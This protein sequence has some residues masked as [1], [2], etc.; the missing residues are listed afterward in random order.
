MP[1]SKSSGL[2]EPLVERADGAVGR[3]GLFRGGVGALAAIG[4]ASVLTACTESSGDGSAA[5][6]SNNAGQAAGGTSLLQTIKKTK[7][8]SVGVNLATPALQFKDEK[9]QEP[10]GY[11]IEL[12]KIMATDLDVELEYVEQPF[13]DLFTGLAAGRFQMSGIAATILPSRASQVLFAAQPAFIESQVVLLKPGKKISDLT[14]LNSGD[15]TIAVR[16]GSSQSQTG[17]KMFPKAK[18]KELNEITAVTQDVSSG[19]ADAAILS[20]FAAVKPLEANPEMTVFNGPPVF[21]DYNSYFLPYN[22][23]ELKAWIDN[24]MSYQISHNVLATLWEEWV[25][26]GARKHNL[27]TVAVTS[28]Y[29]K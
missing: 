21:V 26:P 2:A 13:A 23:F 22:D 9:T 12:L 6:A 8:L 3:R 25:V 4:A 16:L 18:F 29:L 1:E 5:A 17:R 24:W 27:N 10:T 14:D 28:A 19:R 15:V 11:V 20:E 7:K